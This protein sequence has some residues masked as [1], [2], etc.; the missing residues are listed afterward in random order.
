MAPCEHS[1]EGQ[2][3]REGGGSILPDDSGQMSVRLTAALI[4]DPVYIALRVILLVA[5]QVGSDTL[6]QWTI[7]WVDRYL[8][9]STDQSVCKRRN[10]ILGINLIL[11]THVMCIL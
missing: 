5:R 11:G 6:C 2:L 7:R 10:D 9:G 1:S 4:N 8:L 3:E